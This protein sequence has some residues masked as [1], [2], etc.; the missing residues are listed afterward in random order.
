VELIFG[1]AFT[2][3]LGAFVVVGVAVGA[4]AEGPDPEPLGGNP[5]K[6]R[7]TRAA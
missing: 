5:L 4:T 3:A 7:I 1:I 6:V 2:I